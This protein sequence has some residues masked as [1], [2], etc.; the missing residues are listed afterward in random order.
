MKFTSK[1]DRLHTSMGKIM[2][3]DVID[4]PADEAKALADMG[5]GEVE[6]PK[7]EKKPKAENG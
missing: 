2:D 6:K 5:R 1:T 4:L 7:A 3:G